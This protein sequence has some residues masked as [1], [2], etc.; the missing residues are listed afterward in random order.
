MSADVIDNDPDV[1]EDENEDA[2]CRHRT[3]YAQLVVFVAVDGAKLLLR[4]RLLPPTSQIPT[5]LLL[6]LRLTTSLLLDP[7]FPSLFGL[8]LLTVSWRFRRH[9]EILRRLLIQGLP[10]CL[11]LHIGPLLIR[12]QRSRL[13]IFKPQ[14]MKVRTRSPMVTTNL[15]FQVLI[16]F[17][18]IVRLRSFSRY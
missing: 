16:S 8:G 1:D 13:S 12:N 4:F 17:V 9:L 5:L 10:S 15:S 3:I 14:A 2:C 7:F 11:A 18:Y 6:L